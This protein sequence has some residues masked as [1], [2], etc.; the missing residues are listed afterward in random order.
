MMQFGT[1]LVWSAFVAILVSITTYISALRLSARSADVEAINVR[2]LVARISFFVAALLVLATSVSL[3]Y[4]LQTHHFD[5]NYVYRYSARELPP[6]YLFA[7]FWAGQEGSFLLWAFWT[8]ILGMVLLR[9]LDP[10]MER[11]VMP[12]YG[13]VLAF[14]LLLLTVK[15]PF[16][17]FGAIAPMDPA[18]T[19]VGSTF[20]AFLAEIKFIFQTPFVNPHIF[21]PQG[22]PADGNGLNP[23]L[24]NPWM[25]IHPPTLFL[26]FAST[27][28]T[29]AFAI[30]ALAFGNDESW[31]RRAWPWALFCFAV[32]GFGIMLGGYWAYDTLGWGGF[33]GWDPVENGP[34]VPWLMM[35]AFLHSVQVQRVRGSLKTSTL[36]LGVLPFSATLYETF[37][38]RTGI[39]DKFSNH[40]FSTLGGLANSVI[41]WGMVL[42][43]GISLALLIWRSRAL[44]N[45]NDVWSNASSREFGYL[46]AI[47]LLVACALFT[48]IGMSAPLITGHPFHFLGFG[49]SHASSI[50]S[51]LLPTKQTSSWQFCSQSVWALVLT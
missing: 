19:F 16:I 39:L 50:A 7:T 22:I 24:E 25:V 28:V 3:Q 27:A 47:I 15:S 33:W 29:F 49:W 40:S 35:V 4:L 23:L 43:V 32:L 9:K 48:G 13:G 46:T 18:S 45:D 30:S 44:K 2:T 31:Y 12:F 6:G 17:P 34:L 8:S 14:L 41:L 51:E 5:V 38:T 10:L 1:V 20:S 37:L 42:T 36:L 21:S 26:G 11:R